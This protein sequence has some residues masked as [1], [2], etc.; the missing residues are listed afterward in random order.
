[1]LNYNTPT[2]HNSPIIVALDYDNENSV[3]QLVTQLEPSLCKLK[4]GKELFTSCGPS[5]IEKLI[6]SGFD[7]FLDLKFHDI[8]NTVYKACKAAANLGVWMLNVHVSGGQKMLEMAK[9]AIEESAHKPLLIG[10]TILTSMNQ[11]DLHNNGINVNLN[12]HIVNLSQMAYN[13][14][15]DGVVCSAHEA[16]IIKNA[17]SSNFLTVCPG[18]RLNNSSIDDQQ[19][20]MTVKEALNNHADFLVIG[21]PITGAA[22]PYKTLLEII[23]RLS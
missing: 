9:M 20:I 2:P 23:K 12:T 5:I 19:R 11:N 10:V 3:M 17:T 22:D 16:Q 6:I 1:M 8:P 4:V 21:R 18:I 7:V 15:L 13:A 14:G